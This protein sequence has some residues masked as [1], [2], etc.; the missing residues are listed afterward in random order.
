MTKDERDWLEAAMK[1]Y[2]Y[3]DCEALAQ[4]CELMK[5]DIENGFVESSKFIPFLQFNYT[6]LDILVKL[7]ELQELIEIHERNSTNLALCGGL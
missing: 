6:N 2:T 4:I 5:K 7:D 3:N 1:E